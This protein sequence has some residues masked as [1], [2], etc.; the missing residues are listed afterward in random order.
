MS[1]D[2]FLDTTV[3]DWRAEMEQ[4]ARDDPGET[5]AELAFRF[6]VNVRT[7][8]RHIAKLIDEGKCI[9][10]KAKRITRSGY[11]QLIPVYQLIPEKK[12]GK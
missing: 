7:L 4:L 8:Q 10:G 11:Y 1:D 9:Q 2:N 12:A 6:N 5:I 3:D